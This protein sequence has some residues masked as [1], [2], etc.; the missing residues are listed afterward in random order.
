MAG[1]S[2]EPNILTLDAYERAR[3]A[4]R[5]ECEP[6]L[7]TQLCPSRYTDSEQKNKDFREGN[8]SFFGRSG[9]TRFSREL[10]ARS[11]TVANVHRK[12]ALYRF[13][14][15]S[16]FT[17]KQ[18]RIHQKGVPDFTWSKRRDSNPRSPVPETGAIPPSLRLET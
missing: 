18:K 9:G 1:F 17:K 4:L 8:P 5:G 7:L 3:R 16:L 12:F 14:F 2:A 15:E 13:P 6:T 10:R 11:S